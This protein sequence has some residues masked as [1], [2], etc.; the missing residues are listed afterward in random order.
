MCT[1]IYVTNR[2]THTH[3][4][5][6]TTTSVTLA[7]HARRRLII[8]N[9]RESDAGEYELEVI[10]QFGIPLMSRKIA[11]VTVCVWPKVTA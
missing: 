7:A 8:D 1:H 4:Q 6:D 11:N 10:V 2:H 5:R 3:T 9:S